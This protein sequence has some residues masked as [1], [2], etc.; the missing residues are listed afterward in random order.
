VVV[1][2]STSTSTAAPPTA[3]VVEVDSSPTKPT[4]TPEAVGT[5]TMASTAGPGSPQPVVIV[6]PHGIAAMINGNAVRRVAAAVPIDEPCDNV[7]LAELLPNMA[8]AS[9]MYALQVLTQHGGLK[10]KHHRGTWVY[11]WSGGRPALDIQEPLREEKP[12][13][14]DHDWFAQ[15]RAQRAAAAAEQ[16]GGTAH[17]M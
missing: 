11:W 12:P 10:S 17:V 8:S 1:G 13:A 6:L 3:S 5:A 16:A 14:L 9:V 15:L 7:E 4:T 2:T